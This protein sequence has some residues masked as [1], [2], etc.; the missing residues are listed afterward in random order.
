M[1]FNEIKKLIEEIN[2]AETACN[3]LERVYLSLSPYD[4]N[5]NGKDCGNLCYEIAEFFGLD[6][7]G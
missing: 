1:A 4:K 3:L 7:S 2:Q 6:D 5:I